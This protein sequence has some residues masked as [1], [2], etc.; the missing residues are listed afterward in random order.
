MN[1]FR[2][3][4]IRGQEGYGVY[5]RGSGSIRRSLG[6]EPLGV[7]VGIEPRRIWSGR[8][9]LPTRGGALA[10]PPAAAKTCIFGVGKSV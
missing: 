4:A 2:L 3:L 1:A 5:F 10:E 9:R 7:L 6:I 8:P